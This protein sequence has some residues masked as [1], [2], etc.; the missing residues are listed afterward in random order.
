MPWPLVGTKDRQFLLN[1]RQITLHDHRLTD[2][3]GTLAGAHL[4][5][6]EAVQNAAALLDVPLADA[7]C[8]G[9]ADAGGISW[10]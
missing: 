8:H 9:L 4:T 10:P 7:P 6:I 3:D 5:M 1:G 2:P